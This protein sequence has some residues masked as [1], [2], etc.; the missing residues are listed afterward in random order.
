MVH[1]LLDLNKILKDD[2]S[3]FLFGPR[4]VGKTYL[5]HEFI[6]GKQPYTAVD[7][8]KNE[9]VTR[10]VLQ[11]GIFRKEIEEKIS[12]HKILTVFVDEV[13][14]LPQ[15][16]DEVHYLLENYKKKVRF[17]LTGSSARKLKRKG[18]NLLAGRAWTLNLHPLSFMEIDLNLDKALTIGALPAV[19][20]DDD[21]PKRTLKAY[22][23]TYLKEE[24]MQ[25]ALV[26][27]IEGFIRFLDLAG[28]MNGQ[29]INF[30]KIAKECRVSD[31]TIREFFSILVDTLVAFKIDAWSHSV[32]K[33]IRQSP[34]F[35]FFDCGV[36]NAIRGELDIKLRPS[37][38]CYGKLFETFIV[39]ELIKLN[40]Y[41]EA[42]YKFSYWRTNTG[43][44][45]DM[46][47]SKGFNQ[48]PIA[49][50]IKSS[51]APVLSDLHALRSFQSENKTAAL[52]CLSN[53]PQPYTLENIKV[54]PWR[55]GIKKIFSG[56][57]EGSGQGEGAHG[58][59]N[60]I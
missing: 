42:G 28:Q 40:D 44:E 2:R 57:P 43:L 60:G 7:L 11:P 15:L 49:V 26:R 32:R 14:K 30:T 5:C 37:S 34:K 31:K 41:T 36:L 58:K 55:E 6:K 48:P 20:C 38:Y 59:E 21:D 23:D 4:G 13:Q 51:T 22:V 53:S 46:I 9:I 39:Q 16:L 12:A 45:V 33:Q 8:L 29:P 17:I 47:L 10:Y 24:I 27:N 18:A 56:K 54:F 35:Y 19:Y 50:E 52:Y 1:R 3:A 25:E